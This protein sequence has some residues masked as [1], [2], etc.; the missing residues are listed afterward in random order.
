[1]LFSLFGAVLTARVNTNV[2]TEITSQGFVDLSDATV[3]GG[4]AIK[5]HND[6]TASDQGVTIKFCT[7]TRCSNGE[8]VGCS[9]I[10]GGGAVY[11]DG[12][13]LL[14]ED[15][16][17][18]D[19]QSRT[20]MGGA[21]SAHHGC[22]AEISSCRFTNCRTA[23]SGSCGGASEGGGAIYSNGATTGSELY[24]TV[25]D[26]CVFTE[27]TTPGTGGS[28]WAKGGLLC[29]SSIFTGDKSVQSSKGGIIHCESSRVETVSFIGCEFKTAKANDAGGLSLAM[30][31]GTAEL[32]NCVLDG[33]TSYYDGGGIHAWKTKILKLEGCTIQSCESEE[34]YQTMGG[35]GGIFKHFEESSEQMRVYNCTF[36]DNK[37]KKNAR[38]ILFSVN[39]GSVTF[40]VVDMSNCTFKDHSRESVFAFLYLRDTAGGDPLEYTIRDIR[41]EGNDIGAGANGLVNA[42]SRVGIRYEHCTF[43]NNRHTNT[44]E[45]FFWNPWKIWNRT[46]KFCAL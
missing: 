39:Y 21:I 5:V 40:S 22:R 37:S 30:N 4:G 1:M 29:Q 24:L 27:C 15:C 18:E 33:L 31:Q 36:T 3:W 35:G 43:V 32:I 45:E 46:N 14:C 44:G 38:S 13:R 10:L 20:G 12:F 42:Y 2:P 9:D 16:Q 17:F 23:S 25:K 34:G 6:K 41:F 26:E 19:C 7:F 8:N 28:I 11:V